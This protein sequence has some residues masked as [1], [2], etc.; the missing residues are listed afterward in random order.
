MPVGGSQAVGLVA[1][2]RADL[3]V[4]AGPGAHGMAKAYRKRPEPIC[5][6]KAKPPDLAAGMSI[7]SVGL[8]HKPSP[9]Q[10]V[11]RQVTPRPIWKELAHVLPMPVCGLDLAV[12]GQ[13]LSPVL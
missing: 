12:C 1:L 10:I 13:S 7:L 9:L 2:L 4:L 8:V 5:R 3:V 6:R 11:G